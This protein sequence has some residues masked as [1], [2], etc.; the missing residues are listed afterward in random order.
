[1]IEAAGRPHRRPCDRV[2]AHV[3][4]IS[5]T[6]GVAASGA[7]IGDF[8]LRATSSSPILATTGAAASDATIGDFGL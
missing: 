5:A 1:M 3:T 2:L 7:T 6:T 4:G 8:G